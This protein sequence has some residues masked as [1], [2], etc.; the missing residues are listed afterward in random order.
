MTEYTSNSKMNTTGAIALIMGLWFL[1]SLFNDPLI[2]PPIGLV[3]EK[4]FDILNGPKMIN[5]VFI[6]LERLIVAMTI[7]ILGGVTLGS[8]AGT[9]F[10]NR[11]K[12]IL[13]EM[14]K[15]FQ[16]VPPVALLIMAIM[17]F[18]INGIP[19]V[20]IVVLSLVPLIAIQVMDAIENI[21]VKLIEM[22]KVF[23]LSRFDMLRHIYIPSIE[24]VIWSSIIV[25]L[26]IGSKLI[27]MGEVLS[28]SS[29]IG[30]KIMQARL[31]I[32]PESVVAWTIF[33]MAIYYLLELL[34]INIRDS[35]KER[36]RFSR[37]F[38][39]KTN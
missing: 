18:G 14:L 10:P 34:V 19:A 25:S 23:K 7:S 16:V 1:L 24:P 36:K 5:N 8:V 13:K 15:I 6:T 2:I 4:I 28:I 12:E 9:L 26:T 20:F 22:G 21:D 33:I 29:G 38:N 17:W 39:G 31:D 37:E 11:M 27:V 3:A 30:G 35:L 32:E